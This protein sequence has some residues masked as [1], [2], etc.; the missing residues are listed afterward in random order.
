M[1]VQITLLG[2]PSISQ[3][4]QLSEL[5]KS[6]KGI[7]LLSYLIILKR[8]ESREHLADLLWDSDDTSTS[9]RICCQP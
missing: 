1:P 3:E 4:G 6:N 2:S 7:A 5:T 9:L 8:T